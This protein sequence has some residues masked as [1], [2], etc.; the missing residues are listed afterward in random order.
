MHII[1]AYQARAKLYRLIDEIAASHQPVFIKG[2]RNMAV[3]LSADD[4]S[5]IQETL[6]ITAIPGMQASILEGSNSP[7]SGFIPESDLD[8]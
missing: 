5:S 4:W 2:K 1:T 3:L 8:W 7:R 6:Y